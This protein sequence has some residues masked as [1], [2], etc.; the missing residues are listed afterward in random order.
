[1]SNYIALDRVE[2]EYLSPE[3]FLALNDKEKSNIL[4]SKIIPPKLGSNNFGGI[5]VIYRNPIY[6][7]KY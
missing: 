6:K 5:K 4:C 2:E 7:N 1:M 3:K